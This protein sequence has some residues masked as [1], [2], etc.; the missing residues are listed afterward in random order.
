MSRWTVVRILADRAGAI[1][2]RARLVAAILALLIPVAVL[3]YV[4]ARNERDRMV[5]QAEREILAQ[6]HLIASSHDQLLAAVVGLLQGLSSDAA[7]R[8]ASPEECGE[9]ATR[10]VRAHPAYS[11]VAVAGLDGRVRCSSNAAGIGSRVE[12]RAYFQEALATGEVST[13]GYLFGRIS[14]KPVDVFAIR[15]LGASGQP[16]GVI[17]L[18]ID[19]AWLA[20]L[21]RS[22]AAREG[23]Q[24]TV[25]GTDGT[26]LVREPGDAVTAGSNVVGLNWAE[27]SLRTT[28]ATIG[29]LQINDE[30]LIAATVPLSPVAG[31]SPGIVIVTVPT[32]VALA[33]ADSAFR[34]STTALAVIGIVGV[35][36]TWGL[37]TLGVDRP[38]RALL[39][40]T[41]EYTQGNMSARVPI[42]RLSGGELSELAGAFESMAEAVADS[43]EVLHRSATT[44]ALTGLPNRTEFMRLAD[45]ELAQ[46]ETHALLALEVRNFGAVNSTFGFDG[47][48]E[49]IMHMPARLRE[50]AGPGAL[51]GRSAGDEFL[52]LLPHPNDSP[53]GIAEFVGRVFQEP[54]VLFGEPVLLTPRA[55]AA[56]YPHHGRDAV[57][58]SQRAHLA[59]RHARQ[60]ARDFAIYDPTRDEPRAGQ[61]KLLTGLRE[62]LTSNALE[63]H[64]QPK[65]SLADGVVT[66]VEALLRWRG[67][68][69]AYI[70]PAEF[71]PLAEQSGYI[72]QVTIWALEEAAAQ[73]RAWRDA[74]LE[75][76]VGVNV[77]GADFADDTLTGHLRALRDRWQLPEGAID[78]EI[79][80]SAL[81]QDPE[82]AVTACLAIRGLGY[83]IAI[84]DFGTG[85]SPLVYLA[86]LPVSAIKIDMSFVGAMLRDQ[87]A[88]DIVENTILLAHRF[89]IGTV[90]EGVET[91]EVAEALRA[92]G[93]ETGQGFY[94]SRPLPAAEFEEWL[95]T[96][97]LGFRPRPMR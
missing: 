38:V 73:A 91:A 53:E 24:T 92:A 75:L 40:A 7:L 61:V 21:V 6:A 2:I 42:S 85:F 35:A 54:F 25:L 32:Q 36:W 9:I 88:R 26:V 8:E 69:G 80:E 65:V 89:G 11:N 30:A 70:P 44:D 14:Q 33:A 60:T 28:E 82:D 45:I 56:L 86:R 51:I 48:D 81:V 87:R 90:A 59:L 1:R 77:S 94:Y 78:L 39:R 66:G 47:G 63:L 10:I 18:S 4:G 84:D 76:E 62:A 49:L 12:D 15:M 27:Q 34:R 57:T 71:I 31:A 96:N 83:T 43:Q 74:G 23:L 20:E 46:P 64:Y 16:A 13:S 72:R 3:V 97:A 41:H 29:E 17:E 93:C 79:T 37:S 67:A 52:V 5:D 95:R 58:L 55:A 68:D 50:H 22:Q 19:I